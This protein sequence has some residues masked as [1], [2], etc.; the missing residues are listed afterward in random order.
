VQMQAFFKDTGVFVLQMLRKAFTGL[1][2]RV[3]SFT[4]HLNGY[5]AMA[6]AGMMG[7]VI[8]IVG[9]LVAGFSTPGYNMIRDSISSLALTAVGWT[10]TIGFLAL[11]LLV[12][13][14]AA[15]LLYNVKGVRWFHLGIALFVLFGFAMLLIGA[16]H[17]D[18]VGAE[19]TME[20]R[21]HGLTATFTFSLFP[22]AILCFLPGFKRDENWRDLYRYTGVT[23]I[24]AVILLIIVKITHEGSGWFGL[25]ERLLVANMLFWVEVTAVRLF[26]LSLKRGEK[27]PVTTTAPA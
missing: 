19:R 20:G 17:T 22:V 24:L 23:F 8:L 10:Q 1:N 5:S 13:V 26:M 21:I 15:G 6:F 7:P 4:R 14:F 25:A 12:E 11:G 9:D 18:P 2:A 27:E 16:F 3:G